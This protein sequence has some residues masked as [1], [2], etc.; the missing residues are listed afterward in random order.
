MAS[1]AFYTF[2]RDEKPFVYLY[3]QLKFKWNLDIY[4]YFKTYQSTTFVVMMLLGV[5]VMSKMLKFPDT[6]IVMIGATSHALG[7][8]AFGL[9]QNGWVMY[10]GATIASLGPT[11]SYFI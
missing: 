7:R 6:V 4:S 2:Q 10:L 3:T 9:A 1:M 5:P 8:V 11:V